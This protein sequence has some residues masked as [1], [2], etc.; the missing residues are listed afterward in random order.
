MKN[1]L[2]AAACLLLISTSLFAR[3]SFDEFEYFHPRNNATLVSRATN[4][5]I[6]QGALLERNS[7]FSNIAKI[8]GSESGEHTYTAVISD[9]DKSLVIMPEHEFIPGEVVN[10]TLHSG[11]KAQDKSEL[12]SLNWSFTISPRTE[13]ISAQSI[14]YELEDLP[15]T[16]DNGDEGNEGNDGGT[17]PASFTRQ[18][19]PKQGDKVTRNGVSLP[20]DFPDIT[21]TTSDDPDSGY[22][23]LSNFYGSDVQYNMI[24]DNNGDP[25]YYHRVPE[26]TFDFKKQPNG[27]LT[28]YTYWTYQFYAMDST[29]TVV[30]SFQCGNG[31]EMDTDPHD[32]Q[33]WDNGHVMVIAYDGQT[34][35]MREYEGCGMPNALVFG[36][37][38]QELDTEK[39]VVWEWRSWDH[40]EITDATWDINL[41]NTRIDYVHG[42]AVELDYDGNLLLSSRNLDEVTKIDRTTG[43]IIWRWGG[44]N[45]MFTTINDTRPFSHQHDIRRLP[46]GHVTLYDNG[47]LNDPF[48]SRALEYEL[49]EVNLTATLIW[50]YRQTPD[51]AA[52]VMGNTQRLA[53]GHTVIG[54]GS[55]HPNVTE[56]NELGEKEFEM[57]FNPSVISYRAFRFP[58][59]GVAARPYLIAE[60][61]DTGRHLVFNKF[62]DDSVDRYY[63]FADSL[64]EPTTIYDST[65][66]SWY[67]MVNMLSGH[68]YVRVA[69][70]DSLGNVGEYSNEVDFDH[71]VAL[72]YLPGDANMALGEWPPVVT[73]ADVSYLVNY[74]RGRPINAPCNMYGLFVSADVNGDCRTI[75][76]DITCMV[77]YFRGRYS[78]IFCPDLNT[79]WPTRDYLPYGRPHD[80][81]NCE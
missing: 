6:R 2:I 28:Y 62:G 8:T 72:M 32:C 11:L 37:I 30:D 50:E 47:N 63:I 17:D 35:D 61:I 25:V 4:I 21:V 80:W 9:D 46:N 23:F 27:L 16:F 29:Y 38:I 39:N 12:S 41:C 43:D 53:S 65:E 14:L 76:A 57:S 69:A 70:V 67:D 81:P 68:Y 56:L 66:N 44:E 5:V 49:D 78:L 24:L 52:G 40:F 3:T 36:L 10:V 48:Y 74:F 26:N 58:W 73:S 1:V 51:V 7:E 79:L 31:Y 55:A 45:N 71:I 54:W 13:H 33:I 18:K 34:I 59:H 60:E 19:P 42:N 77:N 75:G 20:S 64:P 22:I 15:E